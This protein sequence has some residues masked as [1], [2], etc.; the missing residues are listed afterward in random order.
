PTTIKAVE[1]AEENLRVS[2][3]RY[4]AQ[5]TTST[6]VLDAQTLLT[7]ART[8]YYNALYDHNLAKAKLLRAKGEY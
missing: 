4:K 5:V 8:N 1:Q 2:Q 6:E 7:Q 3:E